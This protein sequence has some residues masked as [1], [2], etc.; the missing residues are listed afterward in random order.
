MNARRSI[1][2]SAFCGAIVAGLVVAL[3]G[4]KMGPDYARPPV[5]TPPAFRDGPEQPEP[6]SLADLPWWQVFNDEALQAVIRE[7]LANNYDLRVA[8]SRIEQARAIEAQTASP[9]YPQIGYQGGVA[10]GRNSFLGTPSPN[11]GS[12][13]GSALLTL[14]AAWEIDL[15]GRIRRADEAALAQILAAEESRRGVMLTLTTSVAQAYFELLE[16]DLE[17]DIANR[18]VASF[19]QTLDLFTKRSTGGISSRL[20]V[21]RAQ[22]NLSQVASTIPELER[23]VAIKENQINLLL[24]RNPG[25]VARGRTLADQTMPVEI[26]TGL[27]SALLERRPDIRQAEQSMV[28]ANALIGVA[29]ADY[30]PRI[31]LTTFFGKV[32]PELSAFSSGSSN[33]WGIAGN[34]AGPVFTGGLLQGQLDQAKAQY[35][36]SR[37]QYEQAIKNAFSEVANT[38]VT[39]EKLG[40]TETELKRQV[41]ALTES[42]S[43]ARERYDVGRSS[44][45]EILDAQVQLY[46][47]EASLARTHVDQFIA[48]IQLYRVLG[49]GWNMEPGAWAEAKP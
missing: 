29:K 15:W 5:E 10:S 6:A 34:L 35:E 2:R 39:R 31:G 33:A 8:V 46:P 1:A 48:V 11:G 37:L 14:N 27:P 45:F 23:Q 41:I 47:A 7:S 38:L 16:L 30:F 3:S 49:G 28:A 22:A 32:S 24:G 13:S 9:L 20:Q 40:G 21:L 36:Q 12:T 43:M 19:Q 17:I 26:P 42:V 18:N 25:P 44:Y 4:C